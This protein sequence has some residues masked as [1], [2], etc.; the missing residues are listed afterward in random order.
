MPT[1][2][3]IGS[4]QGTTQFIG[5]AYRAGLPEEQFGG[6]FAKEVR[7]SPEQA[8]AQYDKVLNALIKQGYTEGDAVLALDEAM[9]RD[10]VL[11]N[12]FK[13]KEGEGGGLRTQEFPSTKI[14]EKPYR[15]GSERVI[16]TLPT[17]TEELTPKETLK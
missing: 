3:Y 6:H 9:S 12:I 15:P 2:T 11:L 17:S 14:V 4:L 10:A 1:P 16:R 13:G 7:V 5:G 8:S